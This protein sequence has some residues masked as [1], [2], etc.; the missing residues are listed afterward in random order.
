[1]SSQGS[2]SQGRKRS[3]QSSNT[4]FSDHTG[5]SSAYDRNF[6]QKLI[7]NNIYPEEY[8]L[9]DGSF[10]PLPDNAE[11]ILD[12]MRQ[13]RLSLSPSKFGDEVFRQFKRANAQARDEDEVIINVLP[14]ILGD[15][16]RA[17][18]SAPN[19]PLTNLAPI[20][21]NQFKDIQP[22]RYY[23]APPEQ[24]D[25]RIRRDLNHQIVPSTD[26]RNPNAA[27]FF[28]EAKGPNGSAAVKTRQAC[29]DGA[30]GARGM[31]ALQNYGQA[32][33]TYDNNAHTYSATYHD[34][35]VKLYAHHLIEPP[36]PGEPPNYYMNQMWHMALTHSPQVCR[37][38]IGAFR[39]ARDLAAEERNM[40][41]D[42]ANAIAQSQSTDAM[43][44]ST[45][46]SQRTVTTVREELVE[47]DTSADELALDYPST[48]T[49]SKR[50]KKDHEQDKA[51]SARPVQVQ[52]QRT[53]YGKIWGRQLVLG[54]QGYFIADEDWERAILRG[55]DVLYNRE[56]HV[57]TSLE[58]MKTFF[59][60][61]EDISEAV[62][63]AYI[64]RYCGSEAEVT[65]ASL[66]VRLAV[67]Y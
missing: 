23:G 28:L 14:T 2:R 3:N 11:Y 48:L 30:L 18:R 20:A 60:P 29:Y 36:Q 52:T 57:Y 15:S 65:E 41:I 8:E 32:E 5:R 40:L 67:L 9:P 7:D 39:N 19:K 51:P 35:T 47:S 46:S 33:P 31:H 62:I 17:H 64:G 44:F 24:I 10:P 66:K 37:E 22:D 45:S 27:N 56:K 50:Q 58:P 13:P 1:M 34:G 6:E 16:D 54:T 38:G 25:Y 26:T 55:Q 12:Q 42:Q 21:P 43:S 4:S 61:S 53:R 59:L 63:K 49:Q